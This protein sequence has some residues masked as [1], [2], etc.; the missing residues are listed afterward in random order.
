MVSRPFRDGEGEVAFDVTLKKG[1]G[2]T[3]VVLGPDGRPVAGVTVCLVE[4]R[5]QGAT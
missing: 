1:E 2:L 4:P 5:F 3:G